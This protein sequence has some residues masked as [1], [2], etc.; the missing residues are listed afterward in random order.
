VLHWAD[1]P[2][3]PRSGDLNQRTVTGPDNMGIRALVSHRAIIHDIGAP[4]RAEPDVG[5]AVEAVEI[6][7]DKRL[8][9][10]AVTG[11]VLDL[12]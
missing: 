6:G 10:G 7:S 8:V 12:E 9:T 3:N 5:R 2:D 11:K 1:L 4:V